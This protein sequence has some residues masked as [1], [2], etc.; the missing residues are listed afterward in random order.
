MLP[1]GLLV[2][3][4]MAEIVA[5]RCGAR[6]TLDSRAEDLGLRVGKRVEMLPAEEPRLRLCAGSAARGGLGPLPQERTA[7]AARDAARVLR[8]VVL[9]CASSAEDVVPL[10]VVVMNQAIARLLCHLSLSPLAK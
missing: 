8:G 3:G 10:G 7:I 5:L 4:E 9:G 2:D 6:E 1:L